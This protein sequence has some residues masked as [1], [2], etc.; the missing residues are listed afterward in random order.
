MTQSA[1]HIPDHS[2]AS[3]A[4]PHA[5]NDNELAIIGGGITG[6]SGALKAIENGADPKSIHIY[7]ATGRTGG[8]IQTGYLPDG[9]PVNMGAEFV[10]SDHAGVIAIAKKLGVALVDSANLDNENFQR[11][12][13]SVM[14]GE[15]FHAAYEPI[16]AVIR[17]HKAAVQSQPDG[18]LA[19]RINQMSLSDYITYL[20]QTVP[21]NANPGLWQR[22]KNFVTR[23]DNH[24]SAEI[25]TMV[26]QSFASESGQAPRNISALAFLHEAS[27]EAGAF[28]DSD[29]AYRVQ[30]GTENIIHALEKHLV[31]Q[32][33]HIHKNMPVKRM[34]AH[35]QAV[36][37]TF[38]G[39]HAPMIANKSMIFLPAYAL[40]KI[41]GLETL[42]MSPELQQS[43]GGAQYTNS[44]KFTVKL[45]E[46]APGVQGNFFA[47]HGMQVWSAGPGQMTF[48]V[49]ADKLKKMSAPELVNACKDSYAAATGTTSAALFSNAAG[50]TVFSNPGDKPCYASA[51]PGETRMMEHMAEAL[52]AMEAHGVGVAGTYL[53]LKTPKGVAVGFMECG[54]DSAAK[55][56]DR[57]IVPRKERS[58]AL[59]KILNAGPKAGHA[60]AH[61]DNDHSVHSR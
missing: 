38:E 49:N 18:P 44:V 15:Q 8:K 56:I 42:G 61:N 28:L 24:V 50:S 37:I 26:M 47:N 52:K 59:E 17:Q 13:G 58:P 36:K 22:F 27:A 32:G 3:P 34:E 29:C 2:G 54:V 9:T 57:M 1:A 4:H 40:A 60:Q 25:A 23:S 10:D 21:V 5:S 31:E 33:V 14:A 48:L 53:P 35:G 39:E 7:E 46:G 6:L 16:A 51:K 11:P 55:V 19:Q 30:G 12:D 20:R 43:L 45:N 41:E